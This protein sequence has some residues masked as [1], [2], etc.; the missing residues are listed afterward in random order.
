MS[1]AVE[2]VEEAVEHDKF[3]PLIGHRSMDP[4]KRV[5]LCGTPILGVKASGNY[6]LCGECRREWDRLRE[7]EARGDWILLRG[8]ERPS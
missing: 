7:A 5:A 6:V 2:M 1:R 8:E 4:A 3:P